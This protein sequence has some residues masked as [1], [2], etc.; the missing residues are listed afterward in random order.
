MEIVKG[1]LWHWFFVLPR[2]IKNLR[3][4]ILLDTNV[5]LPLIR[6][7]LG[8]FMEWSEWGKKEENIF[9]FKKIVENIQNF[10]SFLFKSSKKQEKMG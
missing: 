5:S 9:S 2:W 7:F 8:L 10:F 6:V 1:T 4:I 3:L